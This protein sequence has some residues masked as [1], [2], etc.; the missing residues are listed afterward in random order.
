MVVVKVAEDI[1]K[2]IQSVNKLI[3]AIYALLGPYKKYVLMA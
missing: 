2:N 3:D 1:S